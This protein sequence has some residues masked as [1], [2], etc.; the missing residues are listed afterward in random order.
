MRTK[1]LWLILGIPSVMACMAIRC[2]KNEEGPDCHMRITVKNES[3]KP[4]YVLSNIIYN[5]NHVPAYPD[6]YVLIDI[7][8]NDTL[9]RNKYLVHPLEINTEVVT[10]TVCYERRIGDDPGGACLQVY[11]IDARMADSLNTLDKLTEH[12]K[13]IDIRDPYVPND[14]RNARGRFYHNLSV[15]ICTCLNKADI[16]QFRPLFTFT[17]VD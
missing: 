8:D 12:N 7:V 17:I 4:V 3:E 10:S 9:S 5:W 14:G 2:E 6:K 13:E 16:L 15:I 11:I 1:H